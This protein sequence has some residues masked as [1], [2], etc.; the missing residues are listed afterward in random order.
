MRLFAVLRAAVA[1]LFAAFA[2][3]ALV[4]LYIALDSAGALYGS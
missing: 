2:I 4:G 1:L 3:A